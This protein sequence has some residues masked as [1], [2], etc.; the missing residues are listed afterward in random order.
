[1][2]RPGGWVR[3]APWLGNV[4]LYAGLFAAGDAAQQRLRRGPGRA[5][6]WRQTRHVALVALAFHG[7]FNYVWLRALERL[8]PGR[9]PGAVLAKVLCDQL[10]GAPVAVL[11]FYTG[12]SALGSANGGCAAQAGIRHGGGGHEL[13]GCA[14][15]RPRR[16]AP[17]TTRS[18][19]PALTV[20]RILLPLPCTGRWRHCRLNL[21]CSA[22]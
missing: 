9:A 17:W 4:L 7:N 20:A 12:E 6:D 1:M 2:A 19:I 3:G 14:V 15:K 11:A 10:M 16:I 18:S 21:C 22:C 8:I 5:A 13:G